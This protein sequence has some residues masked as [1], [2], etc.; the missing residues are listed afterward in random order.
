MPLKLLNYFIKSRYLKKRLPARFLVPICAINLLFN[1]L[2]GKFRD[3]SKWERKVDECFAKGRV[4]RY[5]YILAR[6]LPL[7]RFE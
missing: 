1:N 3:H 2:R 7:A 6:L 5:S 4:L